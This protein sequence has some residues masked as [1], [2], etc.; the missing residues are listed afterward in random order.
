MDVG[1]ALSAARQLLLQQGQVSKPWDAVTLFPCLDPIA[2]CDLQGRSEIKKLQCLSRGRAKAQ[3][4][5]QAE[6][7]AKVRYTDAHGALVFRKNFE[8]RSGRTVLFG[9]LAISSHDRCADQMK[10]LLAAISAEKPCLVIL[11]VVLPSSHTK[12]SEE[13]LVA[14]LNSCYDCINVLPY[15]FET[16]GLP[17]CGQRW[18]VLACG[19][20]M[21]PED[22]SKLFLSCQKEIAKSV[23]LTL[24]ACLAQKNNDSYK[25][26]LEMTRR[27]VKRTAADA[28]VVDEGNDANADADHEST[29]KKRKTLNEIIEEASQHRWLPGKDYKLPDLFVPQLDMLPK[30][31]DLIQ[32]HACVLAH[33]ASNTKSTVT[34]VSDAGCANWKNLRLQEDILPEMKQ[35][36]DVLCIRGHQELRLLMPTEILACKGFFG[37][38][39][40]LI[41]ASCQRG[42][43]A[44][45]TPAPV[46]CAMLLL[47]A[48]CLK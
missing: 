23:S 47:A 25:Y 11:D 36:S 28:K 39:L 15:N 27:S 26:E 20:D 5:A 2:F 14:N 9:S 10:G 1:A 34:L 7:S 35:T 46:G 17:V 6:A 3:P 40:S 48:A 8:K 12:R 33:R 21:M 29:G 13:G 42:V 37:I 44:S 31:N 43:L 24:S 38:S 30:Q 45:C 22:I 32:A 4:A 18:L 19:R 41:S 16:L